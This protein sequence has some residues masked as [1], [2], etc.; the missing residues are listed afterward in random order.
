[1]E[2][3]FKQKFDTKG[4]R[5]VLDK[6]FDPNLLLRAHDRPDDVVLIGERRIDRI[7]WVELRITPGELLRIPIVY[8]RELPGNAT[9]HRVCLSIKRSGKH[10]KL[11][12]SIIFTISPIT[13]PEIAKYKPYL[14]V[15]IDRNWRK[16]GDNLIRFAGKHY[17]DGTK[18]YPELPSD[19]IRLVDSANHLKSIR[20]KILNKVRPQLI[21]I[22]DKELSKW[23]SSS[24]VENRVFSYFIEKNI[25][26]KLADAWKCWRI[27]RKNSRK[28][29]WEESFDDVASW[30]KENN[31]DISNEF[32]LEIWRKKSKHL[33]QLEMGYRG[34]AVNIRRNFYHKQ[35]LDDHEKCKY[36]CF[37]DLDLDAMI[38]RAFPEEN[39]RPPSSYIR[40][41]VA[42]GE[43]LA[44]YKLVFGKDFVIEIDPRG[45]SSNCQY[46]GEILSHTI[47]RLIQH[48]CPKNTSI[49][50]LDRDDVASANIWS[51]GIERLGATNKS[52]IA[53]N[54]K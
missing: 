4:S 41:I 31:Y 5:I 14:I 25:L 33:Y 7:A 29:L 34:K 49:I 2:D 1:V 3:L 43:L 35:A 19:V 51:R 24:K 26:D 45:T 37:E 10:G 38:R 12:Y 50:E 46:C 53:R 9:V 48:N 15:G 22:I 54:E 36:A 44:E 21:N 32:Y 23:K 47:D 18:S 16:M 20:D 17:D 42:P 13:I 30:C 11:S 40:Q 27:Y 28:D 52:T 8:H 6:K 39:K